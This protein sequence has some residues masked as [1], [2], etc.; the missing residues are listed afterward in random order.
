MDRD[1][2]VRG[3]FEDISRELEA[4]GSGDLTPGAAAAVIAALREIDGV[5]RVIF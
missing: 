1:L 3:A 5:L 2:E 4:A